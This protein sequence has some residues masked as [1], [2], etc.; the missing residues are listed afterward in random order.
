MLAP[1]PQPSGLVAPVAEK[2][3]NTVM[4]VITAM[5]TMRSEKSVPP[6]R[7][8]TAI[9]Q[10]D[11]EVLDLLAAAEADIVNLAGLERLILEAPGQKPAQAISSVVEGTNIYL[12]L[13][14]LVDM[15]AEIQRIKKDLLDAHN[16][17]QRAESKLQNEGFISKAPQHVVEKEREKVESLVSTVQRLQ[18]LL[19]EMQA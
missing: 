18:I 11:V 12:P 16:E 17:L 5:R 2:T 14:D 7:K 8:I 15:E 3:M 9:C 13:A 1:W 6:G 4:A 10:A 19:Q